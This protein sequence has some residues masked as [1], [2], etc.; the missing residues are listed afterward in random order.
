MHTEESPRTTHHA[1]SNEW[2]FLDEVS[3]DSLEI[4]SDSIVNEQLEGREQDV[5][6]DQP[7][8]VEDHLS[9]DS[10]AQGS[11]M[12]TSRNVLVTKSSVCFVINKVT[13]T[14]PDGRTEKSGNSQIVYSEDVDPEDVDFQSVVSEINIAEDVAECLRKG[15]VREMREDFS[16]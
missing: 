14:Y 15:N 11:E 8:E 10:S 12:Y 4:P 1:Q 9:S 7:P 6:D 13:T 3:F 2:N 16:V 5:V